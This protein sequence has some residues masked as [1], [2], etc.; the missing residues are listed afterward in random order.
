MR[1]TLPTVLLCVLALPAFAQEKQASNNPF[2]AG[3][4]R[5]YDRTKGILLRSAEKMPE[6]NYSFKPVDTVRSYGQIIGHLADAQYLF[7][8]TASGEKNP[9]LNVEKTK[10]SKADL[11]AALKEGFAYC[12]KVYDAMTDGDAAQTVNF[13]GNNVT[14]FAVL[15]T[16]IAHNMEHYGNLV[17]Y[18]RIKGVVPPTSEQQGAMPAPKQE[19]SDTQPKK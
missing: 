5:G 3:D 11:V 9:G 12:D 4:K 13:F 6:E 14:K 17:T 19:K 18:M 1:K 2:S 8:S 10:T 16:N 15:T 7:C